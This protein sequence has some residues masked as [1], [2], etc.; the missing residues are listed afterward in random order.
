M[1]PNVVANVVRFGPRPAHAVRGARGVLDDSEVARRARGNQV[2]IFEA[3]DGTVSIRFDGQDLPAH[4]F[5]KHGGAGG[6]GVAAGDIVANKLL[7][8]ALI[9]AREQ[10]QLRDEKRF[11]KAR[12]RRERV[13]I[14]AS[15]NG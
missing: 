15:A 2:R 8:G 4:A 1:D 7:A 12:Y 5:P 14:R 11:A 9:H 3:A 10:Q 13:L 6:V